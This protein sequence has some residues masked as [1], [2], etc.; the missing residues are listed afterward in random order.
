MLRRTVELPLHDAHCEA[1][2][3]KSTAEA[4]ERHGFHSIALTDHPAPSKKWISSGGHR[5]YDPFAGLSFVAA[6]TSRVRLMT[7]L[8][9]LPYRNPFLTAKSVATVDRLSNGRF[10]LVSGSGYL[11]SEFDVLGRSFETRNDLFDE[12]LEV[13]TVAFDPDGVQFAGNGFTARGAVIDPSP[14]QLPHPPM[15]IGGSSRRARQRAAKFADGWS[16]LLTSELSAQTTRSAPMSTLDDLQRG[17]DELR[18]FLVAAGRDPSGF[19]VQIDSVANMDV[20]LAE[21]DEHH[22]LVERLSGMGVTDMVVRFGHHHTPET[23]AEVIAR[24]GDTFLR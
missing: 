5:T 22:R 10:T 16:P 17:I 23:L 19:S 7:Y 9:V 15:W 12:A 4:V 11:R 3:M 20:A 6:V 18:E 8:A 1:W 24:Y 21:P 13:L 14:V 2:A